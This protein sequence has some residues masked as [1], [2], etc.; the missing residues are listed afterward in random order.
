MVVSG[1]PF[2]SFSTRLRNKF[3]R[4]C[5]GA[6]GMT[7][8]GNML[9]GDWCNCKWGRWGEKPFMTKLAVCLPEYTV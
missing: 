8:K 6:M 4:G 1:K 9:T 3:W 7:V 2:S 5:G